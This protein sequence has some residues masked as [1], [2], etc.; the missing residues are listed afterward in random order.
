MA[1]GF[2]GLPEEELH[3]WHLFVVLSYNTWAWVKSIREGLKK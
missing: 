2:K 3:F 1:G